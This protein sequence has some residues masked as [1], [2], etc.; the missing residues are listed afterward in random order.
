MPAPRYQV[1]RNSNYI[2]VI[3]KD[4]S[5]EGSGAYRHNC[6]EGIS[7]ARKILRKLRMTP[8]SDEPL[9]FPNWVLA[10]HRLSN[11]LRC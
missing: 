1:G 4:F 7:A 5:P 3:L 10:I 6:R 2:S 9:P 8:S 11:H